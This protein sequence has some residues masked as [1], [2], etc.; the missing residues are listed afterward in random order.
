MATQT[1]YPLIAGH[2]DEKSARRRRIVY[3][4]PFILF[5]INS[6]FAELLFLTVA[7]LVMS[8][9]RDLFYKF[10]WTLVICPLGMGAVMGSLINS[11]I[12]DYHYGNKAAHF[13]GILSILV[14]GGCNY[15]C[16]A[17]DYHFGYFGAEAHPLWF[18]LRYPI[19]WIVGYS[20]GRLLFTDAGQASLAKIGL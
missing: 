1:Y 9:T 11:F 19:I 3:I 2:Q 12:I 15:L 18:H 13:T 20:N 10:V 5:Y 14:L 7:I 6:L 8:G 17:L 4:R 16:Y